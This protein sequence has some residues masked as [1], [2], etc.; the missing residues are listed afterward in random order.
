MRTLWNVVLPNSAAGLASLAVLTFIDSWN[1]VEQPIVFLKDA[2]KY[3]MAV[4]LSQV[5]GFEPNLSFACGILSVVPPL[6]LFL[7]FREEMVGGIGYSII[8]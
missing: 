4:F 7:F 2:F 5:S 1:M 6:L 3:P 8:K